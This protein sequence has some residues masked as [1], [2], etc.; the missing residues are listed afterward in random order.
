MVHCLSAWSG[1]KPNALH[2]LEMLQKRIIRPLY[3]ARRFALTESL[4]IDF[5]TVIIRHM[6]TYMITLLMFKSLH[7]RESSLFTYQVKNK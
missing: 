1:S 7:L 3:G 6:F 2:P 5:L 4:F